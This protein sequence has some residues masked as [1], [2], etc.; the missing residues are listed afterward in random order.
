MVIIDWGQAVKVGWIGFGWVFM[1]LVILAVAIWLSGVIIR[2]MEKRK[3]KPAEAET[4]SGEG[5]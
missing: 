1:V 3:E 5:A 2:K 4:N